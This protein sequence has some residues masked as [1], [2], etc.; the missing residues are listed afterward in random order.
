MMFAVLSNP[1]AAVAL[2][3]LVKRQFFKEGVIPPFARTVLDV[4]TA[5]ASKQ[6]QVDEIESLLSNSTAM[7]SPTT[8]LPSLRSEESKIIFTPHSRDL[9]LRMLNEQQ[10][11]LP[12]DCLEVTVIWE[13]NIFF[14]AASLTDADRVLNAQ[15]MCAPHDEASAPSYRQQP[16]QFL[17]Y[18]KRY[19]PHFYETVASN[20]TKWTPDRLD[21]MLNDLSDMIS[22][23]SDMINVRSILFRVDYITRNLSQ[24]DRI[25]V[26]R[27]LAEWTTNLAQNMRACGKC[28]KCRVALSICGGCRKQRYCSKE[29]QSAHWKV[30]KKICSNNKHK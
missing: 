13:V 22:S 18:I 25:S 27:F 6:M 21:P 16:K 20:N 12:A 4:R 17:R 23:E 29:C 26:P 7:M 11:A 30:H 9:Y 1:R 24:G 19:A 15:M 8:V 2:S 28:G 14:K 10:G 3:N 5:C